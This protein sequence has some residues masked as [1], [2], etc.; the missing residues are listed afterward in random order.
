MPTIYMLDTNAGPVLHYQYQ[1]PSATKM[2]K[3]VETRLPMTQRPGY[4]FKW[5]RSGKWHVIT[6]FNSKGKKAHAAAFRAVTASEART[7]NLTA[8][9]RKMS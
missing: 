7:R 3:A 6:I 8:R 1:K 2:K 5:T 9:A 4:T